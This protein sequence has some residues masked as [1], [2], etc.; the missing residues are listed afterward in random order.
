MFTDHPIQEFDVRGICGVVWRSLRSPRVSKSGTNP[1][2]PFL[3]TRVHRLSN[4]QNFDSPGVVW[5]ST[6]KSSKAQSFE[7]SERQSDMDM[8]EVQHSRVI[9]CAGVESPE[10]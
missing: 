3:G 10:A 4:V 5:C 2:C 8:L 1:D 9:R 6:T 7:V